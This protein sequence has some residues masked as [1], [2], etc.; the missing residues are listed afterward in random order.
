MEHYKVGYIAG[1][2]DLFHVGHLNVIRNAKEHCDYLIVGV[3]V[4]DLVKFYKTNP[5]F[6]PFEERIEIV[7]A[8]KYVDRAVPVTKDNIDKVTAWRLYHFDCLF[9]GDDYA[10]HPGWLADK[11]NL[12]SVGSDIQFFP[13]TKTTCSTKIKELINSQ[14]EK[15]KESK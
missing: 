5:P 12:N 3:L 6:I 11:A 1:V 8:I 7:Q 10:N 9:S 13:Y 14:I 2:F 15:N 4:D